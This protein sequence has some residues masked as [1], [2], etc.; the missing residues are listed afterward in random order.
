MPYS[1]VRI[2]IQNYKQTVDR[3]TD[4]LPFFKGRTR[5]RKFGVGKRQVGEPPVSKREIRI[6]FKNMMN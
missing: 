1:Y 3:F 6:A 4:I 5:K 2:I